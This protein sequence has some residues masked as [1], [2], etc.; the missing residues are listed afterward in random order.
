MMNGSCVVPSDR[1]ATASHRYRIFTSM[2]VA[3][4][5]SVDC[6]PLLTVCFIVGMVD[7]IA[8]RLEASWLGALSRNSCHSFS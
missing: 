4:G 7:A 8:M 5:A 3:A 6:L 1:F 2:C